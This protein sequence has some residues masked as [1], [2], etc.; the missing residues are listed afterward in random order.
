[1]SSTLIPASLRN[2]LETETV[3]WLTTVSRDGT[4]QPNPV[5]FVMDGDDVVIYSLAGSARETNIRRHPQVALHFGTDAA[6]NSLGVM[7]GKAEVDA[8]IA[9]SDEHDAYMDKYAELIPGIGMT[10][11]SFRDRFDTPVRIT[12]AKVRDVNA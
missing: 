2:R 7:T 8:S 10:P 3:I 12:I 1:M 5:W 6:G 4:P 11:E 9:P